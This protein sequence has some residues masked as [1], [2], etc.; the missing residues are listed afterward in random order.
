MRFLGLTVALLLVSSCR[1]G[2]D[3]PSASEDAATSTSDGSDGAVA[4]D[5]A[6]TGGPDASAQLFCDPD[7]TDLVACYRF[8]DTTEDRS[9]AGNH[10][11][12]TGTTFVTG[13]TGQALY[14]DGGSSVSAPED[15]SMQVANLTIEMWVRPDALP[16]PGGARVGLF[17]KESQYSI[18]LYENDVVRCGGG[19]LTPLTYPLPLGAWTHLACTN[20]GQD[21]SIWVN[22]QKIDSTPAD[23]IDTDG[24]S[25]WALGMN[26]PSGDNYTGAIDDV[27]IWAIARTEQDLCAAAA[28]NCGP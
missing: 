23:T 27:R 3:Y 25:G 22:G 21:L 8:E 2:F 4:D 15:A 9:S 24:T 28:P 20:D 1:Y 7:N 13:H 11:N 12:A 5:G 17:D 10:L 26:S 6:T 16:V 19:G 14:T 18:F